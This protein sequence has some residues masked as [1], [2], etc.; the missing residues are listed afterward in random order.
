MIAELQT[1]RALATATT[2]NMAEGKLN[3]KN[4]NEK[5]TESF[6]KMENYFNII[7]ERTTICLTTSLK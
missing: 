3:M 7:N 1:K 4:L 5:L 2:K 6:D